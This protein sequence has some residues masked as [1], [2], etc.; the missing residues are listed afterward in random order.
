MSNVRVI[1]ILCVFAP[2]VETNPSSG[3][4]YD[5]YD[6]AF[7]VN[8]V[9]C[10]FKRFYN[11]NCQVHSTIASLCLCH[12]SIIHDPCPMPTFWLHARL[13]L[14][15]SSRTSCVLLTNSAA[16]LFFVPA[17]LIVHFLVFPH[18]IRGSSYGLARFG[19]GEV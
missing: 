1:L 15:L 2:Q 14:S 7:E 5:A 13:T 10:V 16:R 11:S 12:K 19:I 18:D 9:S 3:E 17:T 6:V 4:L 8:G